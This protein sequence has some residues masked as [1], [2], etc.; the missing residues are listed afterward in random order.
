[1]YCP[2][3]CMI[4][5][6]CSIQIFELYKMECISLRYLLCGARNEILYML[7]SPSSVGCHDGCLNG[8]RYFNAEKN[9]G[10]FV[11]L[12]EVLAVLQRKVSNHGNHGTALVALH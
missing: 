1:M 8:R 10:M 9:C 6:T 4:S 2:F 12:Q 7:F 3:I 5:D 11:P